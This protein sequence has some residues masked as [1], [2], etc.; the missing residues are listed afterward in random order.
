MKKNNLTVN[1]MLESLAIVINNAL[2]PNK[3]NKNNKNNKNNAYFWFFKLLLLIFLIWMIKGAFNAFEDIGVNLIYAISKS[4]RSILSVVWVFSLK[5]I[6]GII[7]LYLLYDNFKVF[8][9]STYYDNLYSNNKKLCN[10]KNNVFYIIELL[11]KVSAVFFMIVVASLGIVAIYL[12]SIVIIMLI[13]NIYIISPLI[14]FA[15]LFILFTITF[16]HIKNK[17]FGKEQTIT[18]NHFIFAFSLV[19]IGFFLF[20]Y[21]V[22]SYEYVNALPNEMDVIVKEKSFELQEDMKIKLVNNSKLDNIEIVYD[23]TIGD[24][25]FISFE[26]FETAN[27]KYT[28]VFG[29]DDDLELIF[30]SSLKFR[31]KNVNDVFKMIHATFNRKTIYNYNLFKYPNIII[32]INPKYEK[33]LTIK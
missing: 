31:P 15:S 28:Y 19:L 18:T 29:D 22:G 33:S 7:I 27:V 11:L 1:D 4:L 16:L 21:E 25:M 13:K 23:E 20:N 5:F 9:G 17:F 30:S 32:R 8:V 6:E 2:R 10:R 26:Y 24:E 14:I 3:T 12:F